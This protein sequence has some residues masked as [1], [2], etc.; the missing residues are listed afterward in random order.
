MLAGGRNTQVRDAERPPSLRLVLLAGGRSIDSSLSRS[1]TSPRGVKVVNTGMLDG[2]HVRSG[3]AYRVLC[4]I[5]V[6]VVE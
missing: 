1:M 6:A 2:V 4:I 3:L 5:S